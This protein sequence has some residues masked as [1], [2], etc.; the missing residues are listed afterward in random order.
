[1]T[2][3][4]RTNTCDGCGISFK[5]AIPHREHNKEG[6]WTGNWLCKNCWYHRDYKYRPDSQINIK[7]LLANCR[8]GNQNPNSEQ[9]KGD[10]FEKLTSIW[11]EVKR[12]SVEHDKYSRLPLDHSPIPN[13]ISIKIGNKLVDLSYKI[14]QTKGRHYNPRNEWWRFVGLEVE[15][16]KIFD[17]QICYC[18]SKDM[19]IIDRI[20][21][22]PSWEIIDKRKVIKIVNN[23]SRYTWYEQYKIIDEETIKKTNEIWIKI[24]E[25]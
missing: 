20:Y 4:N 1:M 17:Y 2:Y 10:D 23:S 11:L 5:T 25:T 22:I 21:I 15:W 12:L 13:G 19:K 16:Y 24:R 6:N 9:A 14:P 7:K 18:T 3:Y 8:T